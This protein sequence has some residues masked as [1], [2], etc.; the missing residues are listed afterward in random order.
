MEVGTL[1]LETV[2]LDTINLDLIHDFKCE[3]QDGF[4]NDFLST[5]A[6]EQHNKNIVKTHVL[7]NEDSSRIIGYFSLFLDHITVG[8]GHREQQNWDFAQK[9]F[10]SV[11]I[12]A[13]GVDGVFQKKGYGEFLLATAMDYCIDIAKTAGCTFINLESTEDSVTFYERFKFVKA[14]KKGIKLTIMLIRIEDIEN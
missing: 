4:I 1:P 13:L 7:M 9:H 8:K 3:S 10:P 2:P 12:H 14:G 11:R 5:L 6:S